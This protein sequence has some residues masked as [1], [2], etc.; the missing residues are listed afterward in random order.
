M[1]SRAIRINCDTFP[2]S[3]TERQALAEAGVDVTAQEKIELQSALEGYDAVLVVS[4]K[5]PAET[6]LRLKS[7]RVIARYGSGTDNIDIAEATR[8]GILVTNVPDFCLSEMADHTLAL[9]LA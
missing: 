3:E 8:S 4:G 7:C 5:I 2:I 6:I 1:P 9:I